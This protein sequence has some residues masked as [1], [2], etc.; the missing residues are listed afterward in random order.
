M[1]KVVYLLIALIAVFFIVL[2]SIADVN[3]GYGPGYDY[4]PYGY[5]D[6]YGDD[7]GDGYGDGYGDDYG[8]GY[9]D[10]DH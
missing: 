6:D 5:G 7:Y 9:G 8:D 4:N 1:K 10:D 2:D 3:H